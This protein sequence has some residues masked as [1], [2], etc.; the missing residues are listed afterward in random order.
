VPLATPAVEVLRGLSARRDFV[1]ADDLVF[2]DRFGDL[3]DDSAL[4]RRYARFDPAF[5][6]RLDAGFGHE[7]DEQTAEQR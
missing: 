3:L 6:A 4:R 1:A 5:L 7:A 2:P